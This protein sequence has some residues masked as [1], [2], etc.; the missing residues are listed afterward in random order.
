[1]FDASTAMEL[2]TTPAEIALRWRC[3]PHHVRALIR[4]G[5]LPGFRI[6]AKMIVKEADAERFLQRNATSALA[7]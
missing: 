7:A 6:G 4:S 1:M 3:T 2:Y 5:R